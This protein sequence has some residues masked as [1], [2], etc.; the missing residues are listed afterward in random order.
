MVRGGAFS[1][2]GRLGDEPCSWS[3]LTT[4]GVCQGKGFR[5]SWVRVWQRKRG[6]G[7]HRV[8]SSECSS[9]A[10]RW[11]TRMGAAHLHGELLKLGM[12]IGERTVSPGQQRVEAFAE[13]QAPGYRLRDRDQL[14]ECDFRERVQSLSLA[15]CGKSALFRKAGLMHKF[16][17]VRNSSRR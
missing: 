12:A 9:R 1:N 15:G 17:S 11:R 16:C 4:V 13:D 14:Y 7:R 10:W 3:R 5:I 8:G 6:V 2:L